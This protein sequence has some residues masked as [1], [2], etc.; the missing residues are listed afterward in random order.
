MKGQK[1]LTSITGGRRTEQGSPRRSYAS[2]TLDR[3]RKNTNTNVKRKTPV[4]STRSSPATSPFLSHSSRILGATNGVDSRAKEPQS[5]SHSNSSSSG[6][7]NSKAPDHFRMVLSPDQGE[8]P[9]TATRSLQKNPSQG[10]EIKPADGDANVRNLAP[11][12]PKTAENQLAC[13][14]LHKKFGSESNLAASTLS[15]NTNLDKLWTSTQELRD[16]GFQDQSETESQSNLHL[17]AQTCTID[18]TTVYLRRQKSATTENIILKNPLQAS[19]RISTSV[20]TL[21]VHTHK[22]KGDQGAAGDQSNLNAAKLKSYKSMELLTGEDFEAIQSNLTTADSQ[23]SSNLDTIPRIPKRISSHIENC[24]VSDDYLLK[25]GKR[26]SQILNLCPPKKSEKNHLRQFMNKITGTLLKKNKS[27]CTLPPIPTSAQCELGSQAA[28]SYPTG[29]PPPVAPRPDLDIPSPMHSPYISANSIQPGPN[30]PSNSAMAQL[31]SRNQ[32]LQKPLPKSPGKKKQ[33]PDYLQILSPATSS[34]K[35]RLPAYENHDLDVN[36]Q[37]F[38]QVPPSSPKAER[39]DMIYENQDFDANSQNFYQ[40]PPSPKEKGTIYENNDLDENLQNFYQV[41]P[42]AEPLVPPTLC[43]KATGSYENHEFDGG[44]QLSFYDVPPSPK[45]LESTLDNKDD[46]Y[47]N[48]S[49]ACGPKN[50]I[51]FNDN[52]LHIYSTPKS[53]TP[54]SPLPNIFSNQEHANAMKMKTTAYENNEIQPSSKGGISIGGEELHVYQVP[55]THVDPAVSK[56]NSNIPPPP[57][58]PPVLPPK[59]L[60]QAA[61][62]IPS[63]ALPPKPTDV[64][65]PPPLPPKPPSDPSITIPPPVKSSST[66]E[67]SHARKQQQQ[68]PSKEGK[69]PATAPKPKPSRSQNGAVS[70]KTSTHT[71]PAMHPSQNKL[72][73]FSTTYYEYVA[74]WIATL[75]D[76]GEYSKLNWNINQRSQSDSTSNLDDASVP[77]NDR[78][79]YATTSEPDLRNSQIYDVY[80][81]MEPM[82][83]YVSMA[84]VGPIRRSSLGEVRVHQV[85]SK[86]QRAP[87]CLPKP[88]LKKAL[89]S[90]ASKIRGTIAALNGDAIRP[91]TTNQSSTKPLPPPPVTSSS[92]NSHPVRPTKLP[93]LP[94]TRAQMKSNTPTLASASSSTSVIDPPPQFAAPS[95]SQSVAKSIKQAR[96]F[97]P[98]VAASPLILPSPIVSTPAPRAFP[99]L[100]ILTSTSYNGPIP[101]PITTPGTRAIANSTVPSP[102][103]T[104][105]VSNSYKG[106]IPSPMASTPGL[107]PVA[108]TPTATSPSALSTPVS[109]RGPLPP[110]S[111]PPPPPPSL[112]TLPRHRPSAASTPVSPTLPHTFTPTSFNT[113][114]AVNSN[115]HKGPLPPPPPPPPPPLAM[116][117]GAPISPT[118]PCTFSG[119]MNHANTPTPPPPPPIS[120]IPR[121]MEKR[122]A[123]PSTPPPLPPP[124]QQLPP[125]TCPT[126]FKAAAP[127]APPPPPPPPIAAPTGLKTMKKA[128]SAAAR[129]GGPKPSKPLP[130][131]RQQSGGK[132]PAELLSAELFARIK[133]LAKRLDSEP[134]E[135]HHYGNMA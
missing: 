107:R 80:E 24:T 29:P 56:A 61:P 64:P 27:V 46:T 33:E 10:A 94:P 1:I 93:I 66:T 63:L 54:A 121:H 36:S 69:A 42:R 123:P 25:Q 128:S 88:A 26:L 9:T 13:N 72:N 110:P 67:T 40:V 43:Q 78:G 108:Q 23:S 34:S 90:G 79:L 109:N 35:P 65:A 74:D 59:P 96:T 130:P 76:G 55:P 99:P 89:S 114:T 73:T 125:C 3:K 92:N 135:E 68:A 131:P 20:P 58:P 50:E 133:G 82:D 97:S 18:G 16:S 132:S 71:S 44:L 15:V 7:S 104:P 95:P 57:P 4:S 86:G 84:G 129:L 112:A 2:Y 52:P 85:N 126:T 100:P 87:Q 106:P 30:S 113:S 6:D 116:A 32:T 111:P 31:G 5:H 17:S 41:P 101:S 102:L 120:T 39:T 60:P 119:T 70:G 105:G 83:E 81:N 122:Q 77:Q 51:I 11:P 19:K 124:P 115:S 62:S 21:V 45:Q 91:Q 37:N 134:S 49:I 117:Q 118:L 98:S 28:P 22:T 14:S 12:M 127:Q 103:S 75:K 48:K 53:A 8:P 47:E 38:Y